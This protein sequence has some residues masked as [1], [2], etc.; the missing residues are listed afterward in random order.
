MQEMS[1][2]HL[3]VG[4][5]A[6]ITSLL[7][8]GR[9]RERLLDLGFVPGARVEVVRRSPAGDPTAYRVH[10]TVIALR[11]EETKRILVTPFD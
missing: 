10:N 8:E 1:L 5:C 2:F 11:S 4:R 6:R 3:P 7:L 9:I